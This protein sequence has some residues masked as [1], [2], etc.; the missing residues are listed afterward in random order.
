[1]YPHDGNADRVMG[2]LGLLLV[3]ALAVLLIALR[4]P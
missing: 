2:A 4:A 1:M 3:F